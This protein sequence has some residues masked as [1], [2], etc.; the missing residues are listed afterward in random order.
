MQSHGIVSDCILTDSPVEEQYVAGFRMGLRWLPGAPQGV[1]LFADV[2]R[3][4][5]RTSK[6]S[7][8]SE[9]NV[10]MIL[11]RLLVRQGPPAPAGLPRLRG[12]ASCPRF[13]STSWSTKALRI[14]DVS[15]VLLVAG[16]VSQV[17][18][19]AGDVS[20]AGHTCSC[21]KASTDGLILIKS[22]GASSLLS[23]S[24]CT[25]SDVSRDPLHPAVSS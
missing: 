1:H 22:S 3:E 7:K 19:L 5:L 20:E 9:L 11:P 24:P 4:F 12:S 8:A 2:T 21:A 16:N 14:G 13:S 15:K 17:F 6:V 18:F 10:S 25:S 23:R